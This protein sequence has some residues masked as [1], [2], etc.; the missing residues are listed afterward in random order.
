MSDSAADLAH[1]AESLNEDD[2]AEDSTTEY[3][4]LAQVLWEAYELQQSEQAKASLFTGFNG[5]GTQ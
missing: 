3:P 1:L 2:T 5:I 4:S